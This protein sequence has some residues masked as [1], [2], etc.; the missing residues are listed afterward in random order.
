ML[1]CAQTDLSHLT[2]LIML[3]SSLLM[4]SA[5]A[6]AHAYAQNFTIVDDV[7]STPDH[8]FIV[9]PKLYPSVGGGTSS[10]SLCV[11]LQYRLHSSTLSVPLLAPPDALNTRGPQHQ[12]RYHSWLH[13]P[14]PT[15][16]PVHNHANCCHTTA[17]ALMFRGMKEVSSA[18]SIMPKRK[19]GTT[20]RFWLELGSQ[21]QEMGPDQQGTYEPIDLQHIETR[22]GNC[23]QSVHKLL[24]RLRN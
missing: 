24:R 1:A 5:A 4:L 16:Q 11:L 8:V 6:G 15:P 13:P 10:L 19:W 7:M 9:S 23:Q 3:H 14:H 17:Y 20:C 2:I 18:R 21:R 22:Q 12:P